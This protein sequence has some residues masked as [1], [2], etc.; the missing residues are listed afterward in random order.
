MGEPCF[1]DKK[2]LLQFHD[3][4]GTTQSALSWSPGKSDR[5][6]KVSIE[7]NE[8]DNTKCE[9]KQKSRKGEKWD[10]FSMKRKERNQF[11]LIACYFEQ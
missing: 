7:R 8:K 6:E 4:A 1:L 10:Y 5:G 2:N 3:S 9:A 11:K